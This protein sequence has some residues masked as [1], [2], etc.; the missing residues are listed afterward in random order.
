MSVRE[1]AKWIDKKGML[2]IDGMEFPVI[3]RDV[4]QSYGN[5]RVLVTPVGGD[6]STWV[7]ASRLGIGGEA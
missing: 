2:G 7:D 5:L 6:G 4:K 3:V 1:M